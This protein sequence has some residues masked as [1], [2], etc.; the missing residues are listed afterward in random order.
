MKRRMTDNA[1]EILGEDG[2]VVF[3]IREEANGD[4]MLISPEGRLTNHAVHDFEDEVM[5]ALS[6]CPKILIDFSKVVY[7]SGVAMKSLLSI[8][9]EVD[10]IYNA[11]LVLCS[12][13]VQVMETLK[14]AG[15]DEILTV[16][17]N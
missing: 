5:A 4:T 17:Y 3:S 16:D 7:I 11:S 1:L 9:Q 10:G 6:V 15:L 2:E 14:E 12:P 13:S 8:Q